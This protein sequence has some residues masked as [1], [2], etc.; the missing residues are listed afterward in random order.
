MSINLQLLDDL[1]EEYNGPLVPPIPDLG[2]H[3]ISQWATDDL[4][5][6]QDNS[7]QNAKANKRFTNSTNTDV[8]NMMRKGEKSM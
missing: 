4:R 7:N 2:P 1:V 8:A 6:E 5:D 3:Y